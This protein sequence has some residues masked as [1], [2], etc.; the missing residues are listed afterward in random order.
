MK[1]ITI[2][3]KNQDVHTRISWGMAQLKECG[4]GYNLVNSS[5]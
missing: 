2:L 5:F 1:F 3:S 4:N